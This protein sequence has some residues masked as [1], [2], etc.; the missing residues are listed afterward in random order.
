MPI[1]FFVKISLYFSFVYLTLTIF[2]N[3]LDFK[4][5]IDV[6]GKNRASKEQIQIARGRMKKLRKGQ[7]PMSEMSEENIQQSGSKTAHV[8]EVAM[9]SDY[10]DY[11][12]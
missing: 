2:S 1:I 5:T 3:C 9:I 7:L 12:M 6:L 8:V 10:A 11:R 4:E